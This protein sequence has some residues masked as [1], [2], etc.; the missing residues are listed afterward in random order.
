MHPGKTGLLRKKINPKKSRTEEKILIYNNMRLL[1][2]DDIIDAIY[3][4][5]LKGFGFL[6]SKVS[7]NPR[8]RTLSSFNYEEK[9]ASNWW[10]I[11][12]VKN[13][14]NSKISGD[15]NK[16][17]TEYVYNKYLS[18]KNHIR[19]LSPGSG[20]SSPELKFAS[21]PAFEEI[22]C[23][24][25]ADKPLKVAESIAFENGFTNIS[26][27][28]NDVNSLD[29]LPDYYDIVLFNSSLHHF[30]DIENLLLNKI[31]GSLKP[32]GLLIINEFVGPDRLQWKKKQLKF[33]NKTLKEKIPD[34]Y[35]IRFRSV[36]K[37]KRVTGPGLIR[38]IL[39]DPS[40]A[41]DSSSIIPALRKGFHV[42]EEV[43]L[44]GNILMPLLKDIAYHF[45]ESDIEA[46]AVLNSLFALEDEFLKVEPPDNIFGIYRKK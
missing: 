16:H 7:I 12:A 8:S 15:Q 40:E 11:P 20:V 27:I 34:K 6:L 43:S 25:L 4:L 17:W 28:K 10:N 45:E 26:F 1:T 44:G 5:K 18:E 30:K 42:I 41:V 2:S 36:L 24:D 38:M 33:I 31:T 13:R 35:K 22:T 37:K 3:R 9:Q 23:I 19:L 46:E 39:S 32:E 29:F 21:Y 14:W